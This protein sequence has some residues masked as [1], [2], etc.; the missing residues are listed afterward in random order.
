[1]DYER[2]KGCYSNYEGADETS[3]SEALKAQLNELIPQIESAK[4]N[5][6]GCNEAHDKR[7]TIFK[8]IVKDDKVDRLDDFRVQLIQHLSMS[9]VI[10][11]NR[12]RYQKEQFDRMIIASS[13]FSLRRQTSSL[14]DFCYNYSL[15]VEQLIS[16]SHNGMSPKI[17]ANYDDF[18]DSTVK[19]LNSTIFFY[20][21]S[22]DRTKRSI[23]QW[24]LSTVRY[25]NQKVKRAY[26]QFFS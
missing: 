25:P 13:D 17:Q 8:N 16:E 23:A 19:P 6:D 24:L 7:D 14:D 1:M 11:E 21:F 22:A 4:T 3:A 20:F 5:F 15:L 10:K 2:C 26:M 12:K 9:L 18:G